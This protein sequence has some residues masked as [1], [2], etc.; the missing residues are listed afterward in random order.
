MSARH[1]PD[2]GAIQPPVDLRR[3][4]ADH[5]LA[6]LSSLSDPISRRSFLKVMGASLALAGLGGC[7][8]RPA[9]HIV[10]DVR[11]TELPVPWRRRDR[12][13]GREP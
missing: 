8:S 9:S 11:Q 13:P 4:R 10:P 7:A 3:V 12:S 2:R 5:F 6:Q 1:G